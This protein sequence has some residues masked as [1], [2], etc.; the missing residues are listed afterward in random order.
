[1]TGNVQ[2]GIVV[3][4]KWSK[5]VINFPETQIIFAKISRGLKPILNATVKAHIYRPTGG[6]ISIELFDDGL[7]ADRFKD[8]G[9]YSRHFTNFNTDGE[10]SARVSAGI[11]FFY[12]TEYFN[13]KS[14]AFFKLH[15]KSNPTT[16]V[17]MQK[18]IGTPDLE[19]YPTI[20]IVNKVN[21]DYLTSPIH[22]IQRVISVDSFMLTNYLGILFI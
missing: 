21:L 17:N 11:I 5:D 19:H 12:K 8:D 18:I 13:F 6:I 4:G 15:I 16:V 2:S 22:D 9:I 14:Y 3:E 20:G 7:Y 1:M 10:Y